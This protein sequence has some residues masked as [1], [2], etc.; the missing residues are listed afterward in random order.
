MD[1]LEFR[2][3]VYAEPFTKDDNVVQAAQGDVS[4]QQFWDELKSLESELHG[5]AK[6]DVPNDLAHRLILRQSLNAHQQHKKRSRVYLALAASVAF[7]VGLSVKVFDSTPNY[8]NISQDALAHVYETRGEEGLVNASLSLGDVN[9]K[10][11][12]FGTEFTSEIGRIYS[13]NFCFLNK[14]KALH[15][16]MAGEKGNV[17]VFVLPHDKNFDIRDAFADE[18]YVGSTNRFGKTD[19]IIV[20]EKDEDVSKM[21]ASL[22]KRYNQAI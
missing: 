12:N 18:H 20:G 1:D 8:I 17:S 4:K 19:M 21:K 9:S 2:R 16:V 11:A 13:A 3:A 15:I 6:I 5:A 22:S 14:L 10:L 7:A